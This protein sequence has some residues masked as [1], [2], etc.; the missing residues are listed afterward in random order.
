MGQLRSTLNKLSI[1]EFETTNTKTIAE[2]AEEAAK[3][4]SDDN[5]ALYDAHRWIDVQESVMFA[6]LR[7]KFSQD[8][9]CMNILYKTKGKLL[10]YQGKHDDWSTGETGLGK[11]IHARMLTAIR[12]KVSDRQLPRNWFT[13]SDTI[14]R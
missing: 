5:E 6:G 12:D 2:N 11:N 9:A 4:E 1:N 14:T 10:I 13:L 8:M 3:K 7:Y